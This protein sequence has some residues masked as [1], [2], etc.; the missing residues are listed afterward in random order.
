MRATGSVHIKHD[1]WKL[2]LS[3]AQGARIV[4]CAWRGREILTRGTPGLWAHEE[5]AGCFPLVPWSNR[6]RHGQL[7]LDKGC[8]DLS[9]LK[10]GSPHPL[11]GLGWQ[12]AWTPERITQD[13]VRLTHEY[14][15][16]EWP[17]TYESTF[18]VSISGD[19]L[20]L[21]LSVTNT[22]NTSMPAGLG[23]HPYFPR[24][25][26]LEAKLA[27]SGMWETEPSNPGIPVR[28]RESAV[29][30]DVFKDQSLTEVDLDNCFT[31][32]DRQA[33][34]RDN[35]QGHEVRLTA[36]SALQNAVVYCPRNRDFL[37]IEPVSHVN[38]A[39][40]ISD[41]ASSEQMTLL[42][43]GATLRGEL[44]ISCALLPS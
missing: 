3:P 26:G 20:T 9:A 27:A 25:A 37:C 41:L 22:S 40:N 43:P 44:T 17:W 2:E 42:S 15:Q 6:I 29:A 19:A 7:R 33:V 35:A 4:S 12:M 8:I 30:T 14:A 24:P 34:L 28:K 13:A 36:N 39:T 16:K 32:W 18:D 11:H 38:D 31:G 5:D 23:F 1:N 21:V 10:R